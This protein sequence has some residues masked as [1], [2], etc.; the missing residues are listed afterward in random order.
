MVVILFSLYKHC[1]STFSKLKQ[2]VKRFI[3]NIKSDLF[4]KKKKKYDKKSYNYV[5][6]KYRHFFKDYFDWQLLL[7]SYHETFY[8]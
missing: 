2:K 3:N 7:L 4:L 1:N 8:I 6:S 5:Q